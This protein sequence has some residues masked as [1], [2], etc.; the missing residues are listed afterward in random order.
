MPLCKIPGQVKKPRSPVGSNQS[1][2]KIPIDMLLLFLIVAWG[3]MQIY[4]QISSSLLFSAS[5]LSQASLTNISYFVFWVR[6]APLLLTPF[7]AVQLIVSGGLFR[8]IVYA[9][10]FF[11]YSAV[12]ITTDQEFVVRGLGFTASM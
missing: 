4:F 12:L 8:A 5:Q 9:A 6:V 7:R 2:A 10:V 11:L 1:H 3:C